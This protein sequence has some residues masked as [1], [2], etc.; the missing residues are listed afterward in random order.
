M[1]RGL[2]DFA[3]LLERAGLGAYFTDFPTDGEEED[4]TKAGSGGGGGGPIEGTGGGGGGGG[5][6][7]PLR[8]E[9]GLISVS[10]DG[11]GGNS[12]EVEQAGSGLREVP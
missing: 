5:L 8:D 2:G 9:L 1:I 6:K 4:G 12:G 3:G 10:G 7:L 11:G